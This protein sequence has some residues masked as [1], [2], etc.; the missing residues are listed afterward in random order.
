VTASNPWQI[1]TQDPQDLLALIE[2][3]R[4]KE[5]GPECAR[6]SYVAPESATERWVAGEFASLLGVDRAGMEDDFFALGGHSL[7]ATQ[8]VARIRTHF[9]LE[10]L[11]H[12]IIDGSTVARLAE[13]IDAAT[14]EGRQTL[15]ED[16]PFPVAAADERARHDPFSLTDVQQAYWLGRNQAFELGNISTHVYME[17]ETAETLDVD[18]LERAWQRLVERHDMLR[19]QIDDGRQRVLPRVP[20]YRI[21]VSDLTAASPG[22][23]S[24]H[25]ETTRGEMSHHIFETTRWPLFDIRVTRLPG[26][27]T[28][29][30]FGIDILIVDAGSI[31]LLFREWE[32]LYREPDGDLS[33]LPVTFR[34]YIETA[35]RLKQRK[36]YARSWEYWSARMATLPNAPQ[37]PTAK[38]PRTIQRPRF[39]R[40]MGKLDA[41]TWARL[42]RR[43]GAV[44][45]TPA[46]LLATAFGDVLATWSRSTHFT[47]NLTLFNRLPL[48]PQVSAVVGDFTSVTLLEMTV[49]PGED[50]LSRVH[51]V[52]RQL[53]SDID[54]RYVG[55]VEVMREMARRQSALVSMPV[56]FTSMLGLERALGGQSPVLGSEVYGISQTP[57]V[58]LDHIVLGEDEGTLRFC[59]DAVEELFPSGMLDAMFE[60]YRRRLDELAGGPWAVEPRPLL[61][62]AQRERMASWNATNAAV[63]PGLLHEPFAEQARLHPN[64]VAVVAADRTL[65]FGELARE[66][67][68]LARRLRSWGVQPNELVAVVME[69]GWEQVVAVLGV[70]ESGAAYVPIDAGLPP[71]R[72]MHL[73]DRC[74]VRAIVTQRRVG[75]AGPWPEGVHKVCVD[76]GLEG[77]DDGP[78]AAVQG[79]KDLAYVIFTSGSTG[80]PKGV[81]IEHRAALNTVRDVTERNAVTA[82]DRVLAVSSLSFD[83]SVYDIFGVLGAG[84]AIVIL[85]RSETREPGR[86]VQLIEQHGVTVWN[87]VP[88]LLQM[89]VDHQQGRNNRAV[90]SLRLAMLSGD[91]LPVTLP[92]RARSLVPGLRVVTMGGATEA[93]IW[94]IEYPVGQVDPAWPSVPYGKPMKNQRWHVLGDGLLPRPVWVPGELYIGG[95]GLA[96]GYWKEPRLTEE[97]FVR[98]PKTGERL[99]RTGDWG[100]YLDDGNIEFL[101]RE[102]GQVKIRGFRVE[103][104]EIDAVLAA[105]P[106]VREALSSTFAD[107]SGQKSLVAYVVR[108][109]GL[110]ID[111][112]GIR[113]GLA[114]RL[115]EYMV[116]SHVVFVDALPLSPNGKVDRKALPS[117]TVARANQTFVAPRNEQERRIAELWQSVLGAEKI[118]VTDNFFALGGHSLMALVLVSRMRRELGLDVPLAT[119]LQHQTIEA[120]V[121]SLRGAGN[122]AGH[123]VT[124]NAKGSRPPL[125]LVAGMGGYGFVFE[126]LARFLGPDQPVWI[127]NAIGADDEGADGNTTIENMAAIYESEILGASPSGPLVL[128][129]YSF[130]MLVAFELA[131][132]LQQRGRPVPLLVS[133]DGYAPG[134]PKLLPLAKRL[135][136]HAKTFLRGE[137][138]GR[139]VYVRNRLKK[140]KAR[141]YVRMGRPEEAEDRIP[142][143]DPETDKRLRKLG[144]RLNKASHTYYPTFMLSSAL[145]L[146]KT[147][148]SER[149]IG[150]DMDDPV[151]GWRSW[152]TGRIEVVTVFGEHL[153]MFQDENQRLMAQAIGNALHSRGETSRDVLSGVTGFNET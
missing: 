37:L 82:Q 149:W 23:V 99:Y 132:S 77:L 4:R 3:E 85:G 51:R 44:S 98:H 72:R 111:D 28:R 65:R 31:A 60:S 5:R 20:S 26:S 59:W 35:A 30:H 152:T 81:M 9:R 122:P 62:E 89:L 94:S 116:P 147:S 137:G 80:T 69:R 25:I 14:R 141:V 63:T 120:L 146:V 38:T 61:P 79:E 129:G 83:L 10:A 126:G 121:A 17:F 1:A 143:A 56:V 33:A 21:P 123:I 138:S 90:R 97:R 112:A 2:E 136:S 88:A 27:A 41:A 110:D 55:G 13:R 118:G 92:D 103:L 124:L 125:V 67:R 105:L 45:V 49:R 57:Q 131:R 53:W 87:S 142:L 101:G 78:L 151:Y 76:G 15:S 96:R 119:I 8:L 145:L 42:K 19:A 22:Q 39:V 91:W 46:T 93:A 11:L 104:G 6:V 102:D 140:L 117:P 24:A 29:T 153:K 100:R 106:E 34:D 107:P 12:W 32:R 150:T 18:R 58:S 71:E 16:D 95:E 109:P 84:G 130:G 36:L 66:A 113:A 40:R 7:L 75:E 50:F 128:G 54:H 86:W 43:A 148:I 139:R 68:Q 70:L 135:A 127:L 73:L 52:Q 48:H 114:R 133:F 47:L 115:P 108:N 144:A 74:D 64:R 134:F